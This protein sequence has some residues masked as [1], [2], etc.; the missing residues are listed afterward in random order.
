M[1]IKST[2][3]S[4]ASYLV[5]LFTVLGVLVLGVPFLVAK[6]AKSYYREA[7]EQYH[8]IRATYYRVREARRLGLDPQSTRLDEE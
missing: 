5:N 7:L 4:V 2:L 3:L 1:S 8:F 6:T